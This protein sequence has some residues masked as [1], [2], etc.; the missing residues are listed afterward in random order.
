[1]NTSW[2]QCLLSFCIQKPQE[3]THTKIAKCRWS[4]LLV[5]SHDLYNERRLRIRS[6]GRNISR[7]TER[8]TSEAYI[9]QADFFHNIWVLLCVARYLSKIV[10]AIIPRY[11]CIHTVSHKKVVTNET[12][13]VANYSC[14][15]CL[16]DRK[17]N[18]SECT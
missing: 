3:K 5:P 14:K 13:F 2:M 16:I 1:M 8:L 15:D 18:C 7:Q 17:E 12:R 10:Y 4:S 9:R 6:I 11:H